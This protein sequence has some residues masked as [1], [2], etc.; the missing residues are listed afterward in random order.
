MTVILSVEASEQLTEL[1]D[2]LETNFSPSVR[3]KFQNRLDKY[4]AAI[5]LLPKG[6]PTS[7][8]F[9]DCRK[10]VVTKQTSIIYRL[11]EG[12]V[13]I[14]AVIDNRSGSFF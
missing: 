12:V 1:F 8:I 7:E 13:E 9:P 3:R 2:Y 5:K 4:I 6:F 10:C 14:V 11:G